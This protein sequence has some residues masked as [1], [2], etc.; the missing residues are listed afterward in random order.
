MV[1]KPSR[2]AAD[3][4]RAAA[5]ALDAGAQDAALAAILDAWRVTRDPRIATLVDRIAEPISRPRIEHDR[6]PD[7]SRAWLEIARD[8]D[9]ADVGRLL[10]ASWPG[11]WTE[12][13]RWMRAL[14]R[15]P[16][17]PRIAMALAEQ[18]ALQRYRTP[19]AS[20]Y[21]SPLYDA[22][23]E[24][25]DVRTIP[26]LETEIARLPPL[27]VANA[28][29][30][31]AATIARIRTRDRPPLDDAA[32]QQLERL[33][34]RFA[35]DARD[36]A[37]RAR[38][39]ADFLTAIYADPD[40]MALRQVFADWLQER[41]D[42]RGELIALQLAGDR[43]PAV[44]RREAKLLSDHGSAWAGILDRVLRKQDRVWDAGFVVGGVLAF[45]SRRPQLPAGVEDPACATLRE[46]E[47]PYELR[48]EALTARLLDL[49]WA[50]RL[51]VLRW[52]SPRAALFVLRG[53]PRPHLRELRVAITPAD[54]D[55]RAALRDSDAVPNLEHLRLSF[56]GDWSE[57]PDLAWL[58]GR[59][60]QRLT[61]HGNPEDLAAWLARTEGLDVT[62]VALELSSW[63]VV[64][65]RA[66]QLRARIE[67]TARFPATEEL[68]HV[69]GVLDPQSLAELVIAKAE[70]AESEQVTDALR[71]FAG[72]A[73]VAL[74]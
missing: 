50:R 29:R 39:R 63:R 30:V 66:G 45:D 43:T 25:G 15:F 36:D 11:T 59:R 31:E 71:R 22:L 37:A 52:I 57:L 35:A 44:R 70:L 53:A 7:R 58:R 20:R 64:T 13:A 18:I 40:D 19:M 61:T 51:R 65:T 55:L 68:V 28:F 34:S 24:L 3:W 48:D 21:Y 1:R 73:R 23:V 54:D 47:L 62:E 38:S 17:D 60:L 4:L 12:A 49:P 27:A 8:K 5:D 41:G 46:L 9:P 14:L 42:P 69:L 33:E 26:L 6:L 10:A 72:L 2:S 74:Q 56:A 67:P 32:S 16:P